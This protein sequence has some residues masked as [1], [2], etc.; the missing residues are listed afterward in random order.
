MAK[1][2]STIAA[3]ASIVLGGAA[4]AA[5]APGCARANAPGTAVAMPRGATLMQP[6]QGAGPTCPLAALADVDATI[7]QLSSG[8]AIT[9]VAPPEER[10]KLREAVRDMAT[11]QAGPEPV[12]VFAGCSCAAVR[13][14]T[15][16]QPAETAAGARPGAEEPTGRGSP[17]ARPV[18]FDT[19]AREDDTPTG[20]VLLLRVTPSSETTALETVV[21]EKMAAMREGCAGAR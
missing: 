4:M 13:P 16:Q 12:D 19:S 5:T 3:V 9:F 21:R 20:A 14:G 18:V 8:I 7:S 11:P 1:T 10:E 17:Q 15:R 2:A 6:V